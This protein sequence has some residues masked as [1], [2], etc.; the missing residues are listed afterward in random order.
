MTSLGG[1][2]RFIWRSTRRA[3]I[4]VVGVALLAVGFIMMVTPGP[5]ILFLVAGLALLATEFAWAEHLLGKARRQAEKAGQASQKV[6]G[7]SQA[8]GAVKTGWRKLRRQPAG[9]P[10]DAPVVA[11]PSDPS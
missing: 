6:P 5:G 3:V 11:Q 7:V 2:L 8:T 9:A 10:V 1:L 4:F